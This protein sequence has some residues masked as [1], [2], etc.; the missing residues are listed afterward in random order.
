[1][2]KYILREYKKGVE[3]DQA[4]VG[5]EVARKW[6]WPFAYDQDDLMKIHSQPDFDPDT[7]LYCYLGDE[8]IGYMFSQL[9]P[10]AEGGTIT[11]SIDFPRM[12]PGHTSAAELLIERSFEILKRNGFPGSWAG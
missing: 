12:L 9:N 3:A 4:R 10:V 5:I 1:M 2:K 6:I 7:R 8:M 11:A